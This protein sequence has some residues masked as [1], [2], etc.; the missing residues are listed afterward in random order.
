MTVAELTGTARLFR[1][2]SPTFAA[3]HAVYGSLPSVTAP[4]APDALIDELRRSGLEGRGGAGFPVWRKLA[5]VLA[6]SS[7][8]ADSSGLANSS[9]LANS[10]ALANSAGRGSSQR[11]PVVIGNGA[12]GE[13]LSHKDET[14]LRQA[15]HLVLDGLLLCQAVVRASDVSLYV[16]AASAAAVRL[17][18][19]ERPDALHVR[20][21]IA[22]EDFVSGEAT[23]V[24]NAFEHGVS[25]PRDHIVHLSQSGVKKRPTLVQNV[26]TL[27][28]LALIAR[29]GAE[30]FRSV[31]TASEPGTR[32]VTVSGDVGTP[33]LLEV[34]GGT[35]LRRIVDA[36]APLDEMPRAVLVGGYHGGWVPG[37]RLDSALSREALAPFGAAPGAGVIFVLGSG[38]CGLESAGA[39]ADYL[40]S[41]SARQCGPCING[42]PAMASVLGSLAARSRD[43]RLPGELARLADLVTGR[44]SCSHPDGTARF[45]LSS[46]RAFETDVRAHL[47]GRCEVHGA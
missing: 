22:P 24:A 32:L 44:G 5:S 41:Q 7:V 33:Q 27:A 39:I 16:G 9:V 14:L 25:V 30:W 46:L 2:G 43:P 40:A 29:F 4:D 45:V 15:P 17:A 34:A 11:Q 23:A 36:C 18:I 42:L 12:D 28:Q 38:R 35:S 19:A 1:A 10:S 31:G 3:H 26:E 13:P 20:V 47:T 8:L 37:D 21:L 6:N